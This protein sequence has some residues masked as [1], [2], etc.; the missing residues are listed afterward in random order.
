MRDR[1]IVQGT[2]HG[3][4]HAEG[5]AAVRG[6][7]HRRVRQVRVVLFHTIT[8]V[9]PKTQVGGAFETHDPRID[10]VA[11]MHVDDLDEHK[12]GQTQWEPGAME[13]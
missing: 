5:V 7:F 4:L 12:E 1:S 6:V 10:R 2:V 13:V 8:R 11:L 9:S 3:V